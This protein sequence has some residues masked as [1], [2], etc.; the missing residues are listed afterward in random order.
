MAGTIGISDPQ[1]VDGKRQRT[2]AFTHL[3]S[4]HLVHDR[5]ERPDKGNDKGKVEALVK[6]ARRKFMVPVPK[7]P[8]LQVLNERPQAR[9]LE[10][11]DAL[12]EGNKAASLLADLEALHD[13]PAA[14]FETCEHMPGRVSSTALARYRLVDY[15]APAVH[16]HNKV[17]EP[18]SRAGRIWFDWLPILYLSER[19]LFDFNCANRL[20]V[21]PTG[22]RH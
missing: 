1:L 4:H 3:Q 21:S 20:S 16:A 14:P 10:R 7:V 2:R 18:N 22:S 13:L 19:Q 6:T 15:S 5:F 17:N 11:L 8:D 9:C 12:E